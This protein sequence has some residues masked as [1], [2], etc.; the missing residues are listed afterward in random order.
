MNEKI[1]LWQG[2][3]LY[4]LGA[5]TAVVIAV[6]QAYFR[7]RAEIAKFREIRKSDGVETAL[8]M[9]RLTKADVNKRKL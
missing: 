2:Y 8:R 1:M 5:A 7:I 3:I 6:I 4:G 9:T